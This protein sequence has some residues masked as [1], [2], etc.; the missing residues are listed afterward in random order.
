MFGMKN[1]TYDIILA[2]LKY[3]EE[4]MDEPRI[5]F[6]KVNHEAL[7]ISEPRYGRIV[8]IMINEGLI[9]G[10]S[11]VSFMGQTYPSYK[12]IDPNITMYGLEYIQENKPSAK[13]YAILKEIKEW[14]PG[15]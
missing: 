6:S 10:L 14:I 1:D 15:L 13:V 9:T 4:S 7:G 3:L 5:D 2:I 8:E 11:E 12:A